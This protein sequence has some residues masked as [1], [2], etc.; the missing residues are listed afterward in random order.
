VC[1]TVPLI[2]NVGKLYAEYVCVCVCVCVR[3]THTQPLQAFSGNIRTKLGI[4]KEGKWPK[5]GSG[6]RARVLALL[7][8]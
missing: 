8:K 7:T 1:C 5:A 4:P 6:F 2:D 3:A